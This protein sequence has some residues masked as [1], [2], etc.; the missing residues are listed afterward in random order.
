MLA[1]SKWR[2]ITVHNQA[3]GETEVI[4]P[5]GLRK[6]PAFFKQSAEIIF[7]SGENGSIGH[8]VTARGKE[9]Y[10]QLNG[11][12]DCLLIAYNE[13]LGRKVNEAMIEKERY[14]LDQYITRNRT[15]YSK[16]KQ[17]MIESTLDPMIAGRQK[18]KRDLENDEVTKDENKKRNARPKKEGTY[19]N[20]PR[21][22]SRLKQEHGITVSGQTHEF[23]HPI[24]WATLAADA[25]PALKI[26]RKGGV[27]EKLEAISPAYAETKSSHKEHPGAGRSNETVQYRRQLG[28]ALKEDKS[29][30]RRSL[31]NRMISPAY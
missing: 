23:E 2:N 18:E 11:R 3:T 24:P 27:G 5:G 22:K 25:D 26:Q 19:G 29:P 30:G 31:R 8:F 9:T 16:Y 21:E 1:N 6:I 4:R 15:T 13:S 10:I 12:Q 20:K 28:V 7:Q 17:N 14:S